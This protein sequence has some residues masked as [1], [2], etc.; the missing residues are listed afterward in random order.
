[1]KGHL[2]L[3]ILLC[4]A[5]PLRA[6]YYQQCFN[7]T[8][9]TDDEFGSNSFRFNSTIRA[10]SSKEL[11][12]VG[13]DKIY[14]V[15]KE[16]VKSWDKTLSTGI[17]DYGIDPS[18]NV[19]AIHNGGAK[20]VKYNSN[21][22]LAWEKTN[23][24]QIINKLFI[25]DSGNV[26]VTGY[27]N[28][29]GGLLL[30]KYTSGGSASWQKTVG[31]GLGNSVVVTSNGDVFAFGN[32]YNTGGNQL[33]K[34]NSGGTFQW[35]KP[36]N[37]SFANKQMQLGPDGNIYTIL[38]DDFSTR[39]LK[40]AP[41][42]GNTLNDE[43][44]DIGRP[45]IAFGSS[46]SIIILGSIGNDSSGNPV[47]V[48]KLNSDFTGNFFTSFS[49]LFLYDLQ[50]SRF[51]SVA[52][53]SNGNILIS[54]NQSL[55]GERGGVFVRLTSAGA[56][57]GDVEFLN[58]A[59]TGMVIDY[60]G[61][62]LFSTDYSCLKKLTLCSTLSVSITSQPSSQTI[63]SGTN[64]QF[65]VSASGQ[66]LLY[67]WRKGST[68]LANNTKYSGVHTS[69]LTITGANVGEDAGSYS[70]Q[71]YDGCYHLVN[72]QNANLSF[73]TASSITAQPAS[74]SQCA[75]TDAIFQITAT[76]G[77][78][79]KYQW[80]KGATA[81]TE[82]ASV[83]GVTTNKL[84]LKGIA[85]ASAGQYYCEVTSDCFTAP[86][87]SQQAALTLLPSTVISQQPAAVTTCQG[88]T[89]IFTVAGGGSGLT[90]QWRKGGQN[91]TENST[92]VGTKSTVLSVKNVSASEAGDYSCV[93]TGT[94]GGAVTS[95]N[96]ALVVTAAGQITSQ[97]VSKEVCAGASVTFTVAATGPNLVYSWRKGNTTL[98][99]AGKYSG[100]TSAT[101]NVSSTTTT[102]EGQYSC[103]ISSSCG[104]E[105]I[106]AVAQLSIGTAPSITGKSADLKLC[107]GEVAKMSVTATGNFNKYQWKKNG[108]ALDDV[109][110]V[111]GSKT[112]ELF[113]ENISS[114][115][116]GN[117]TCD[118]STDCGAVQVS[119]PIKLELS[120]DVVI[121][122]AV[123]T[124]KE[125]YGEKVSLAAA[126]SGTVQSYQWKKN[127]VILANSAAIDG[128]KTATLVI[129]SA[130]ITD[131]GFYSCELVS[132]CGR[133]LITKE[134][135]LEVNQPPN[136]VLLDINCDAFPSDWESLVVDT[137]NSFGEY[138]VFKAGSTTPLSG[139]SSTR[140]A[141]VYLIVKSNET[142]A[143]TVEWHNDCLITGIERT[144]MQFTVA[145]NP[146]TGIFKVQY[147]KK[148]S[149][150][151][152]Y[153]SRGVA[154]LSNEM[155]DPF[156]TT[157]NASGLA[158]GV[159]HLI[160]STDDG[161]RF[162]KRILINK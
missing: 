120:S 131:E 61:N 2:R 69:T 119:G 13:D 35:Q 115:D 89:A 112:R 72:S 66:G 92:F 32:D 97:P 55:N 87:A 90:Y 127:G 38:S 85:A 146:S 141:G 15:S 98:T 18:G 78:N 51:H 124:Q 96:A 19:V 62:Y 149:Q 132:T 25:D 68:V 116:A 86:I 122:D 106:S 58:V 118:V 16:G 14:R 67:Q 150:L 79:V 60:Q 136:L 33:I 64:V 154:V 134:I 125:C 162:Y 46:N 50:P 1:M 152:M 161:T 151:T 11:V 82:S 109:N 43:L 128:V 117:Y 123:G 26:Y 80:K 91:L 37:Y 139:L 147:D 126:V 49:N 99:N 40:I 47:Y 144:S 158:H 83:V 73:V 145:P 113:L 77:Q 156:E 20:L 24:N 21:G 130:A 8:G 5:M 9:F 155:L 157:V 95:S 71:V 6:Q 93:I 160:L 148:V 138:Q 57:I 94:C 53:E 63:C 102:E 48:Y 121:N 103:V 159:Y 133:T 140:N 29:S 59:A 27:D 23:S 30:I 114:D 105:F 153:D 17:Y 36:I 101:L 76:G 52:V 88:T 7:I 42:T 41:S 56:I 34:Y 70:C 65:S 3:L 110:G 28:A 104:S 100:V 107:E 137:N 54:F 12:L 45:V 143:D 31:S 10:N 22:T 39:I 81:L 74:V 108:V 84:T 111:L 4:I 129:K 75:N 135:K 44:V 142:C